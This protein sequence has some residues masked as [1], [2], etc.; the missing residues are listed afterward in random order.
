MS[1]DPHRVVYINEALKPLMRWLEDSQVVEIS[2]NGPG[3]VFV[4]RFGQTYMERHE[5][6]A[7]TESAIVHLAERVAAYI[8]D[9]SD[10]PSPPPLPAP[11]RPKPPDQGGAPR[12][13]SMRPGTRRAC[14]RFWHPPKTGILSPQ[15]YHET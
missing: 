8:Q 12:I 4:E 2:A 15:L 7:L 9:V 11:W 3:A 5:L 14:P 10:A 1:A 6:P 13:G